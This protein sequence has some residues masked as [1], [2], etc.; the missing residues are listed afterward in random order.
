MG[1]QVSRQALPPQCGVCT[2][3]FF[4]DLAFYFIK[5][6]MDLLN[7]KWR[8]YPNYP[9]VPEQ[10]DKCCLALTKLALKFNDQN[11]TETSSLMWD[12]PLTTQSGYASF[13]VSAFVSSECA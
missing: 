10:P 6:H 5:C 2:H 12:F 3:Q 11:K 9:S 7:F 13:M 4:V 1:G 8:D